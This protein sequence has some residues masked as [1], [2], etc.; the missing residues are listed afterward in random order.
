VTAEDAERT[1][2]MTLRIGWLADSMR[3]GDAF[4]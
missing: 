4:H 1:L 2:A 3:S